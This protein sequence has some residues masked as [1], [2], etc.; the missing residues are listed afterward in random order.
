MNKFQNRIRELREK[1]FMTQTELAKRASISPAY[2]S[3]LE[4][5]NRRGKPKTLSNIAVALGVTIDELKG[6][7]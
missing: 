5:G 1:Q 3:D 6:V 4:R 7:A 2:L